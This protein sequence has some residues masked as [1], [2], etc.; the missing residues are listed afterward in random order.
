MLFRIIA[1]EDEFRGKLAR[2]SAKAEELRVGNVVTETMTQTGEQVAG[3][4]VE[5]H[6]YLNSF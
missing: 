5:P 3:V 6:I 2:N 4:R 1:N